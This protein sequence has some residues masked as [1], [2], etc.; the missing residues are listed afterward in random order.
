MRYR[1][2][3]RQRFDVGD[4]DLCGLPPGSTAQPATPGAVVAGGFDQT[5]F[6]YGTGIDVIR[7]SDGAQLRDIWTI[8]VS[9][10]SGLTPTVPIPF[11]LPCKS[12]NGIAYVAP[13]EVADD[14]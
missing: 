14:F 11:S 4:C 9:A 8:E 2:V 13:F 3:H 5:S 12:R 7:P 1:I 6:Y 10:R